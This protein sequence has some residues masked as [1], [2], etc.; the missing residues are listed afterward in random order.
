MGTPTPTGQPS[1]T[2]LEFL[3][4]KYKR[5]AEQKHR[6]R[7]P[8]TG[9]A[10]SFLGVLVLLAALILNALKWP[11]S[12]WLYTGVGFLFM[13]FGY[14]IRDPNKALAFGGF[15]VNGFGGIL[16]IVFR[17]GKRKDDPVVVLPVVQ[18]TPSQDFPAQKIDY[19]KGRTKPDAGERGE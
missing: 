12:L 1:R 14:Y 5:E 6:P 4:E 18:D 8:K 17:T 11:I 13:I 3:V 7:R 9:V 15:V 2:Q 19:R 10:V 16:A